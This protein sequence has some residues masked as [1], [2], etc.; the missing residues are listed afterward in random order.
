MEVSSVFSALFEA[1]IRGLASGHEGNLWNLHHIA[2]GLPLGERGIYGAGLL[3]LIDD[4]TNDIDYPIDYLRR[5]KLFKRI[6]S[7]RLGAKLDLWTHQWATLPQ[8]HRFARKRFVAHIASVAERL[9]L[10]TLNDQVESERQP[11]QKIHN[12]KELNHLSLYDANNR[13]SI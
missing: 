8:R 9:D 1:G 4:Y 5:G 6:S 13:S 2:S 10:Y 11:L 3:E 12:L 7:D